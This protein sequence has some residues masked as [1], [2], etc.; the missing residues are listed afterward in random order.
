[1]INPSFNTYVQTAPLGQYNT[2]PMKQG[3]DGRA[4]QTVANGLASTDTMTYDQT[5]NAHATLPKTLHAGDSLVSSISYL[6]LLNETDFFATGSNRRILS[7][8]ACVTVVGSAPFTDIFRPNYFGS[9][10]NQ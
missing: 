3:Y 2:A 4:N 6:P 1:M 7:R 10:K 9:T 8:M 5:L